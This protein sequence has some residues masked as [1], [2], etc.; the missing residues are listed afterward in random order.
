[1]SDGTPT[2]QPPE[3][4]AHRFPKWAPQAGVA[5]LAVTIL[6][7]MALVLTTVMLGKPVPDDG[8]FLVVAILALTMAAAGAFLGGSAAASGQLPL[9]GASEHP[10]TYTL[11]GGAAVFAI[12]LLLGMQLY[13]PAPDPKPQPDD[14]AAVPGE[15]ESATRDDGQPDWA[16][17]PTF[18]TLGLASGFMPD[19]RM[20]IV[21]AGGLDH[22]G[23]G[24][25]CSGY[26]HAARPDVV[27]DYESGSY[28]LAIYAQSEHDV[29][30]IVRA[31]DGQWYCSD[32][33]ADSTN[34]LIFLN[35]PPDG[36]YSIWVGTYEQPVDELPEAA[37]YISEG[38]P[39]MESAAG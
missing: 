20:E 34:P 4:P 31:P 15:E 36:R 1:M 25:V 21:L 12:T 26:I 38:V 11:G 2:P 7:L 9:P 19:P 16:A 39:G 6:F 13:G 8:R 10:I 29:M 27:L 17:D 14:E 23:L 35:P 5:F 37:L 28:P 32:D 24:D 18:T 3:P 22:V 33:S 30:L